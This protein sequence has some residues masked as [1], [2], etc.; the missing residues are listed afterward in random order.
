VP[1]GRKS[2]NALPPMLS[3]VKNTNMS[4]GLHEKI[5]KL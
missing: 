1:G 2:S 5:K 3:E 4:K